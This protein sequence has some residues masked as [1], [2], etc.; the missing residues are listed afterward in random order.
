MTRKLL[1]VLTAAVLLAT[2]GGL[3]ASFAQSEAR[4]LLLTLSDGRTLTV[5]VQ[6]APGTP[7]DQIPVPDVGAQ[8]ISVQDVTP[9]PAETPL[10]PAPDATATTP[11]TTS[12]TPERSDTSLG[13]AEPEGAEQGDQKTTGSK[14]LKKAD[15]AQGEREGSEED[16]ATAGDEAEVASDPDAGTSIAVPGPAPVGVPNFFIEKFRIPPFLL[17]IYQAAGIEYGIRWEIL[18]A[19]NEIETDYG[20]NLNVSYAG[21][22]GW[23]QFMPPTWKAYGVDANRDG[24]KDPYNPVD[25]IFAAARYLRAAGADQDLRKAIFAYNHADWY[26]DSVLMRAKLIAGLP[27]DLIGSLSGLTQGLFPVHATATY[28]GAVDPAKAAQKKK[29]GQ[30]AAVPVDGD[31]D[32]RQIRIYAKPGAPATAVQDGTI[33]DIGENDRLGRYIRLRDA[34]GNTYTYGHLKKLATEVA[35]AKP[36]RAQTASQIAKELELPKRDPKP[37]S[38]ASTTSKK[39]RTAAK[40]TD[41]SS[42]A[43]APLTSPEPAQPVDTKE[44]LFANPKRPAAYQAGGRE[45]LLGDTSSLPQ[46]ATFRRYFTVDYG[47]KRD[48]VVLKPLAIGRRVIAGTILGRI[49]TPEGTPEDDRNAKSHLLFEIRPAGRGAPRIDPKPI[50]DGWKLLE[51][52]AI[53]RAKGKNPLFGPD[54]KQATVGQI[55]LMDKQTLQR[56]VLANPRIEVYSGGR[57]DIAAG[58][59]DRRVLATLEFMAANGMKPT[60]TSLRTGHGVYTKSG[61]ISHHTTGTAVDIAAINGVPILGHQGEGS[62]TDLAVRRLLTLQGTMKPA[63]II[64]LMRYEGTDNTVAMSDHHDHIH[65][66]WRPTYDPRSKTGRQLETLLKPGQWGK[67]IDRLNEIENPEIPTEPSKYALSVT[68]PR[69]GASDD[70][71]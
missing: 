42:A 70:A 55:L 36:S 39:A 49:G 17:P 12:T 61:N 35:V 18:A 63:Q 45:Q 40:Q 13:D 4:T 1:I 27:T 47:M 24:K 38:A 23:M 67:L 25:A 58:V 8:V 69:D 33:T 62:V 71:E 20:R 57:R 30:N 7:V 28:A 26:V 31:E 46:D 65:I 56:R 41:T 50:L 5:S 52:T 53:Y 60:V 68:P 16:T 43:E 29:A 59:I 10:P 44:R 51:S 21:A 64:T 32:R 2:V 19:I 15:N 34:Y 11:T 9:P 48:D 3:H 66:G 37:D 6:A 54:A 22:L 14:K